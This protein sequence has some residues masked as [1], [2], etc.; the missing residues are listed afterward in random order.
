MP[1]KTSRNA[2]GSGTIRQRSDGRW[3]ARITI[4]RNAGTGKQIQKSIY[5]N[6]QNEVRKQLLELCVAVDNG[7]YIEPSKLTFNQWL[8]IWAAE[9]LGSVK[10]STA[11]TYKQTINTKIKPYLG[12]VK[13][14]NLNAP[15]LQRYYNNLQKGIEGNKPLS[16]KTIKD[17]HGI[18]HKALQQAVAI[19]YIHSNPASVCTLPRITK[20]TMNYLDE[21]QSIAFLQAIKGHQ[22]EILYA[23]TLFTG[24]RQGEVL[25]LTWDC[26]DFE[27]GT[28]HIYRQYNIV[29]GEY[30]F[31][32]LKNDK[33]RTLTPAPFVMNLLLRQRSTQNAQ[34]LKVGSAWLNKECFVF[35][36]ELGNPIHRNAIYRNFKKLTGIISTKNLRFHD[37]RHSYAVA[38]IRSGDDIKSIQENMGHH[39]AAFTLDIYGHVSLQMKQASAER[40]EQ[41]IKS[42]NA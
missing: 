33:P 21:K 37:L 36:N 13:L 38:A 4:G 15:T 20:P 29:N 10:E 16:P 23:V 27:N 22:H 7:L 1:R 28:I 42:L 2:Q 40:M 6:S 31:T 25:G 12:A 41:Y 39:S 35:T 14:I 5:G 8:D 19:G 11:A 18:I 3:E 24:M 26:I 9:Y 30:K 34:R 32:T 17:T